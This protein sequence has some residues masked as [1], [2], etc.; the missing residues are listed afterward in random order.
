M[1][2]RM[3]IWAGESQLSGE[4]TPVVPQMYNWQQCHGGFSPILN[5]QYIKSSA[6]VTTQ[7]ALAGG[8]YQ[9]LSLQCMTCFTELS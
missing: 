4:D 3:R 2:L 7:M 5:A 1:L 9:V 6:L 8:Y